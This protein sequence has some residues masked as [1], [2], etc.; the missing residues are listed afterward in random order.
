MPEEKLQL[1]IGLHSGPCVTG[2]VGVRMPR[3]CLFGGNV[4]FAAKMESHGEGNLCLYD[5]SCWEQLNFRET[6]STVSKH[7]TLFCSSRTETIVVP[8]F[9]YLVLRKRL[10]WPEQL[11]ILGLISPQSLFSYE[12]SHQRKLLHTIE[13][14][15][16]IPY[17]RTW[18]HRNEGRQFYFS[19]TTSLMPAS[20]CFIHQW[21]EHLAFWSWEIIVYWPFI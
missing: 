4:T 10:L 15:W 14:P 3:Y 13:S 17:R 11:Q 8:P 6:T 21:W 1:R 5:G 19:K 2:V 18:D 20:C 9:L 12:D 16:W 7:Q